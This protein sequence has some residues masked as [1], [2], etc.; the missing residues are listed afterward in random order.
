MLL[1]LLAKYVEGGLAGVCGNIFNVTRN[2]QIL[3][4]IGCTI[5]TSKHER[6]IALCLKRF[7]KFFCLFSFVLPL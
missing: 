2:Y 7:G 1:F 6:P 3:F 5:P 4:P